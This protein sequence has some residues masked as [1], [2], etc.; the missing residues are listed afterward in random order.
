MSPFGDDF[1]NR[2]KGGMKVKFT[3]QKEEPAETGETQEDFSDM[4]NQAFKKPFKEAVGDLERTLL[5]RTLKE[6][7]YNQRAAA[8]TIG[9][10]YDQLRGLLKKHTGRV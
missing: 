4:V 5:S 2:D 1:K 9:L 3:M 7:R 10:S 6:C 8:K